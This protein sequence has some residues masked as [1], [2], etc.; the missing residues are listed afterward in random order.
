[1]SMVASPNRGN[2]SVKTVVDMCENCRDGMKG[3]LGNVRLMDWIVI[4]LIVG[5]M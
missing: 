1:M 2:R 5:E 4:A 3:T